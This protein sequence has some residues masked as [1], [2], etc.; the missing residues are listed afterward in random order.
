MAKNGQQVTPVAWAVSQGG[1]K[2]V[3]E[4]EV[5]GAIRYEI[6]RPTETAEDEPDMDGAVQVAQV[7]SL[8]EL[9]LLDETVLEEHQHAIAAFD[10]QSPLPI[11]I[12]VIGTGDPQAKA[13]IDAR[14]RQ[15]KKWRE[16][17]PYKSDAKTPQGNKEVTTVNGVKRTKQTYS[18]T[19]NPVEAITFDPNVNMCFPGAIVQA[20]PAIENGYLI[21]AQIDD[22][23]RTELGV[24]VDR[25]TGRKEIVSPPSASNV[26]AAIG[27]VIGDDSPGSSDIVYRRVEA[28]DSMQASLEL[29][30]SGTYGGFS[31]S[32]DI[33]GKR[34]ETMN[35]VL[36]FLRERGF[37]A[38]CDYSNAN[39]LFKNSFTE[40]KLDRL[41][42]NGYI[43]KDNLPLLV[44]S[45]IYGRII[46]FTF[47][48][49]AS[50]TE[51]NAAL[52]SSY[53][54]FANLEAS[55]KAH[56]QR[57]IGSSEVS[58]ISK[59]ATGEQIKELLEKGTLQNSFA[60]PQ[61][62]K[63][64]V[65]I[66][67]TLQ[68]LDGIPAKMSETTTYDQVVWGDN[69]GLVTFKAK[70]LQSSNGGKIE[71]FRITI[72][73]KKLSASSGNPVT[74][75]KNF[76]EDGSGDPF[77]ITKIDLGIVDLN[78]NWKLSPK[79]LGWFTSGN[80]TSGRYPNEGDIWLN[81][82]AQ[83]GS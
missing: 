47:T 78:P 61:K 72:D 18:L 20:K 12:S 40:E 45:V 50:E 3:V 82:D 48:S 77:H 64:Y 23:D 63:S 33:S 53:N 59:G 71:S 56:Y 8:Q 41:V 54:G 69:A 24:S 49:K 37:T 79:E 31:A 15:W 26:T 66:G 19:K 35:T 68:T 30:I 7:S 14:L 10:D 39:A 17:A 51:I 80:N 70:S 62:Y 38:F 46:V 57:I 83:R 1:G 65:R 36:V 5:P 16:L 75:S 29:G 13:D 6:Y 22:S 55:V 28:Y 42:S 76:N 4:W 9:P 58:V 34:K 60:T 2:C 81:Y 27:K 74:A 25:L 52:K 21:S 32:L 43:G 44:N 67:Y 73:G 11:A